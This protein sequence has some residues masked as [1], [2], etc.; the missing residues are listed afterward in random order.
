MR[1]RGPSRTKRSGFVLEGMPASSTA[2][3]GFLIPRKRR[4]FHDRL[5]FTSAGE[6]PAHGA[7][8]SSLHF[9]VTNMQNRQ[10]LKP[11]PWQV[12]LAIERISLLE[13]WVDRITPLLERLDER[14]AAEES[15][16]PRNRLRFLPA[17]VL[18]SLGALVGW[19]IFPLF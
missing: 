15:P 19:R 1:V 16:P 13:E 7:L 18:F 3:A 14:L 4:R 9:L 8:F 6:G 17:G 2:C 5:S 12:Q 11:A 10:H